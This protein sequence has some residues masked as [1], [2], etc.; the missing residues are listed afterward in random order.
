MSSE[1]E[2]TNATVWNANYG[3]VENQVRLSD[4]NLA[5]QEQW[6]AKMKKI[7]AKTK[8]CSV[9]EVFDSEYSL[10]GDDKETVF[11]SSEYP[12]YRVKYKNGFYYD[13]TLDPATVEI[14]LKPMTLEEAKKY[15]DIIQKDIFDLANSINLHPPKDESSQIHVGVESSFGVRNQLTENFRNFILGMVHRHQ[16]LWLLWVDDT[17]N[18][19]PLSLMPESQTLAFE[20]V[21]EDIDKKLIKTYPDFCKRMKHDVYGETFDADMVSDY[22]RANKYHAVNVNRLCKKFPMGIKTVE[23]RSLPS[24]KSA[25][26]I[27]KLYTFIDAYINWLWVNPGKHPLKRFNPKKTAY[28]EWIKDYLAFIG[29]LKLNPKDYVSLVQPKYREH[30]AKKITGLK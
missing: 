19:P 30:C 8:N 15:S 10:L 7:C 21:I 3:T 9:V 12:N 25:D 24:Q 27:I 6:A 28:H 17:S 1:L 2:F 14:K 29:K 13:I 20:A 22:D 11:L 4:E 26:T 23:F 5:A 16:E 18:A